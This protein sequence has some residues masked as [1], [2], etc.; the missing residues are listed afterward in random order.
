MLPETQILIGFKG[1][2]KSF[3]MIVPHRE[4]KGTIQ[5]YGKK[6]WRVAY[7][8]VAGGKYKERLQ[9]ERSKLIFGKPEPLKLGEYREVRGEKGELV[10][11]EV[12]TE[13][14]GMSVPGKEWETWKKQYQPI[15]K[16][17]LKP[18]GTPE[19]FQRMESEQRMRK[20]GFYPEGYVGEIETPFGKVYGKMERGILRP[21]VKPKPITISGLEKTTVTTRPQLGVLPSLD[22]AQR[23]VSQATIRGTATLATAPSTLSQ[24]IQ[25]MDKNL[26]VKVKKVYESVTGGQKAQLHATTFLSPK[27]WWY[28]FSYVPGGRKPKE[29]VL[30]RMKEMAIQPRWQTV[31]ESAFFNPAVDVELAALTALGAVKIST[32]AIG[33]RIL[34]KPSVK[35]GLKAIGIGFYSIKAIETLGEVQK[36]EYEKA[37]GIVLQTAAQTIGGIAGY[38]VGMKY[39]RPFVGPRLETPK[40]ARTITTGEAIT[41]PKYGKTLSMLKTIGKREGDIVVAKST[42]LTKTTEKFGESTK[43]ITTGITRGWQKTITGEVRPF[44]TVKTGISI[45]YEKG[46]V[47]AGMPFIAVGEKIVGTKPI[48]PYLKIGRLQMPFTIGEQ[49]W[50]WKVEAP[51]VRA[52]A[53]YPEVVK[54][55]EIVKLGKYKF[56]PSW[57]KGWTAGRVAT[58]ETI[59]PFLGKTLVKHYMPVFEPSGGVKNVITGPSVG[60]LGAVEPTVTFPSTKIKYP[61]GTS[62]WGSLGIGWT[63]IREAAEGMK[64]K[65][66]YEE[67]FIVTPPG[68]PRVISKKV[69]PRIRTELMGKTSLSLVNRQVQSL[70]R[71]TMQRQTQ[72]QMQKLGIGLGQIPTQISVQRQMQRQMQQQKQRQLQLQKTL[73]ITGLGIVAPPSFRPPTIPTYTQFQP[74]FGPYRPKKRISFGL[75]RILKRSKRASKTL[76]TSSLFNIEKT[77]EKYG[78]FSLP[79]G[80]IP[81]RMFWKGFKMKGVFMEFPTQQQLKSILG[82][83]KPMAKRKKRRK[84]KR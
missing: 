32:S 39:Y 18:F 83:G 1:P 42:L 75:R 10:G 80:R 59:S 31:I 56:I 30:E 68:F 61:I 77:V 74:R 76:P 50:S 15:K 51:S 84:K 37:G 20:A 70:G 58:E 55:G 71:I 33:T 2:G 6:G 62:F 38:K 78:K 79:R 82:G 46:I 40:V 43:M 14:G 64:R 69:T 52:F 5:E 22:F 27:G 34:A 72:R 67:E 57:L 12:M 24:S 49:R 41:E 44:Y 11:Y 54:T 47:S 65:P 73:S 53:P 17:P 60:G 21:V 66:R 3:E 7:S 81:E 45:P 25:Y 48:F 16:E 4:V 26:E 19:L 28:A 29:I 63:A 35:F 8:T 23:Q 9:R 36:G 13:K